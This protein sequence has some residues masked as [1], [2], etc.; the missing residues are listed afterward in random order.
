MSDH[1]SYRAVYVISVAAELAGM[2][3]QTLRMYERRGL[4]APQRTG[5]GSRRYSELDIDRLRRIQELTNT[6]L[7][8]EGVRRVLALEDEVEEL[9]SALSQAQ[10]EAEELRRQY[11]RELVPVTEFLTPWRRS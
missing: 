3:A 5:G 11:R 9:R 4:V 10:G 8:L 2:H 6:G 7:N 1:T